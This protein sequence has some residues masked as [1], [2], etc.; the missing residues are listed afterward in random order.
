MPEYLPTYASESLRRFMDS[1]RQLNRVLHLNIRAIHVL[2]NMP[3]IVEAFLDHTE[4]TPDVPDVLARNE[5]MRA[6]LPE[7]KSEAE[8][9]KE[10]SGKGFP[11]LHSHTLVALWGAFEAAVEDTIVKIL[12]SEPERLKAQAFARIK[13]SLADF[14]ASDAEGRVRFLIA[15]LSRN[16]GPTRRQGVDGFEFLLGLLGLSGPVR[17]ELKKNSLGNASHPQ[18]PRSSSLVR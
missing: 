2:I 17:D 1:W 18:C 4:R 8:F 16:Q 5:E 3:G 9:A 10:E 14:H 13:I 11:L 12:L 7:A 6:W 15:E